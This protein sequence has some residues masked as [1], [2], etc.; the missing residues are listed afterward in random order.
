MK[1]YPKDKNHDILRD[2]ANSISM[3]AYSMAIQLNERVPCGPI[4]YSLLLAYLDN[5]TYNSPAYLKKIPF[6]H[7]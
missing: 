1:F 6:S 5:C 3:T 4:Q 2:I 7:F